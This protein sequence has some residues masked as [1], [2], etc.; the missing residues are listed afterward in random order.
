[1]SGVAVPR[2]V[3]AGTASGVGKTT[4]A[5]GLMAALRA[6]GDR[7]VGFK[8]G[9]DYIDPSYHAVATGRP[10]R[11]LDAH[12]C[13]PDLIAPLLAH[14]AEHAD[15]AVIEGVMGLFDGA[16][17]ADGFAS[18]AHVATLL[19]APV[20]LVVDASAM[21]RSVAA[22]VHGFAT[23]DPAV[24]VAGVI[25]NRVGSE[26]HGDLVRAALAPSDIPV[27]GVVPRDAATATPSRHLGLVPAAERAVEA[28][29]TVDALGAVVAR[30]VDLTAI[31]ALARAAPPL[32]TTA[33]SPPAASDGHRAMI[34][35]AGGPAFTFTY[36]E[37]L[38]LLEA[39]GSD[40]ARFDPT[41]DDALPA[42]TDAI[43][44]GGGFPEAH[45]DAL[46]ANAPLRRAIAAHA[47]AG[48]PVLA[49]CG[50]LLYLCRTLDGLP[51]CGVLPA[52]G[53]VGD[54]L[55]LGYRRARVATA[56]PA[57]AAG[58]IA[59]AH[60]FH[61]GR[62]T[63]ATGTSPAWSVEQADG[64]VAPEGFVQGGV[65]ASWLHTHWT[66]TPEVAT[67]FVAAATACRTEPACA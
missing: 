34:A 63:P 43:Y 49:E 41:V 31:V 67:R 36:T 51:Q 46:S 65:H 56:S 30:H 57:W 64:G 18:T 6:T 19:D 21:A 7:V 24:R 37:H 15:V 66:A 20:I 45:G 61:H 22:L 12:L 48:R 52:D 35:V 4:V 10:P 38:E 62:V 3:V 14:A 5:T 27:L 59:T 25:I 54:R 2:V 60:E 17:A 13:G 29:A 9:P 53:T 1:M 26:R 42:G 50:G 23:F 44:L 47:A 8:V 33:W 16:S 32:H 55:R 40:V 28:T 39:A 11:N 58:T